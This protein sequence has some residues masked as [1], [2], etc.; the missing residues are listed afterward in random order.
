[1][2][3]P[4]FILALSLLVSVPLS[5]QDR[6]CKLL[7]I[8]PR[9]AP[10]TPGSTV[11]ITGRDFPE[12]F[13]VYFGGF[14]VRSQNFVSSS[15]LE[16]T[17]PYL[18][19]GDYQVRVSCSG[20][21]TTNGIGF[22]SRRTKVDGQIHAAVTW[23]RQGRI[24]EGI[25]LLEKIAETHGDY[26]VR[27]YARYHQARIF[28]ANR[29]WNHWRMAA[30]AIFLNSKETKWSVQTY[31]P[32][33]LEYAQSYYLDSFQNPSDDARMFDITVDADRTEHPEPRFW[34]GLFNAR[35]GDVSKARADS[36]FSVGKNPSNPKYLALAAFV[37]A[38]EAN[39]RA[40]GDFTNRART[41]L[42]DN[43]SSEINATA[44]SLLGDAAYVLGD[45][46]EARSC[47]I[48]AERADTSQHAV[49]LLAA[50]KHHWRGEKE[51]AA[52]LFEKSTITA[53][54]G[55]IEAR[56]AQTLL[57]SLRA[58]PKSVQ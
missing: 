1:M 34:R 30:M 25:A 35:A 3:T 40:A 26:Q 28:F 2:K 46:Q 36:D 23:A 53:P 45:K 58:Q 44:W 37:S 32:Y 57:N 52:M 31:W 49:A 13:F 21:L 12:A 10:S 20:E 9:S 54:A 14:A 22:V 39:H 41:A 55:S 56:E 27:A 16:V 18:P 15:R 47:W 38:L 48:E 24:T 11:V 51:T 42:A 6:P 43:T 33:G 7:S 5:A 19:P 17:T 50:K 8:S 4:S 29:D